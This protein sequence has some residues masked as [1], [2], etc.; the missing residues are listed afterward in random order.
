MECSVPFS[1]LEPHHCELTGKT[2]TDTYTATNTEATPSS[3][4][5]PGGKRQRKEK[6][7]KEREKRARRDTPQDD[8]ETARSANGFTIKKETDGTTMKSFSKLT[9]KHSFIH[10]VV[11]W[12]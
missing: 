12:S 10:N 2:F 1:L 3:T 5:T 11:Q 6:A 9:Y 8:T 7:Q 4:L